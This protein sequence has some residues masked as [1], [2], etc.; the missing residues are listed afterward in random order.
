[1]VFKHDY[2]IADCMPSLGMLTINALAAADTVLIPLQ[3]QYLSLKGLEHVMTVASVS[4]S[5]SG[6]WIPMLA[7]RLPCGSISRSNTFFP[8]L[9]PCWVQ[10]KVEHDGEDYYL[11]GY[12]DI[13]MEGLSVRVR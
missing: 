12:E 7:E 11:A 3:A 9:A 2:I 5:L 6:S 4:S 13:P 8:A 1:M 10:T